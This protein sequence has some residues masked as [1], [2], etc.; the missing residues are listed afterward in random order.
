MDF[1][2]YPILSWGQKSARME[3]ALEGP[4]RR[5]TTAPPANPSNQPAA[6]S[7]KESIPEPRLLSCPCGSSFPESLCKQFGCIPKF[8]P[9]TVKRKSEME[10]TN[11]LL[12]EKVKLLQDTLEDFGRKGK[13]L[14]DE[15]SKQEE[16]MV[17]LNNQSFHQTVQ[18][19]KAEEEIQN[20]KK[21]TRS[22]DRSIES[23]S[24]TIVELQSKNTR[25]MDDREEN[26]AALKEMTSERDTLVD[27]LAEKYQ[28]CQSLSDQVTRI[29]FT[30]QV[31]ETALQNKEAELKGW[32]LGHEKE[33]KRADK[34]EQ[35]LQKAM[36]D[37]HDAR[38]K[39]QQADRKAVDLDDVFKEHNRVLG[40][41]HKAAMTKLEQAMAKLTQDFNKKHRVLQSTGR[42][43]DQTRQVLDHREQQL[44]NTRQELDETH[45]KLNE[46]QQELDAK[47]QAL[48]G[49]QQILEGTQQVLDNT[50]HELDETQQKLD[51]KQEALGKTQQTLQE[52]T[53]LLGEITQEL[54]GTKQ[55]LNEA[56]QKLD[57]TQRELDET[58]ELCDERTG[59]ANAADH[60]AFSDGWKNMERLMYYRKPGDEEAC[61]TKKFSNEWQVPWP[62]YF[63]HYYPIANPTISGQ[64]KEEIKGFL[65]DYS[66]NSAAEWT[67]NRASMNHFIETWEHENLALVFE[68]SLL[69]EYKDEFEM[70]RSAVLEYAHELW[71][72]RGFNRYCVTTK[73]LVCPP[74]EVEKANDG[75]EY[76]QVQEDE[77][78]CRY[79]EEGEDEEE[80]DEEDNEEDEE[81]DEEND[82]EEEEPLAGDW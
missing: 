73:C 51:A 46:K 71:T 12:Q 69:E 49:T 81:D 19:Q 13:I 62:I 1:G 80:D 53:Q 42:T 63:R 78:S 60:A 7:I 21:E 67:E 4:S 30:A 37:L 44:D 70:V 35:D 29:Q 36:N 39:L 77:V 33:K 45:Q 74:E 76:D 59:M 14:G 47:Q 41:R 50:Q 22:K 9:R 17:V 28:Q 25:L 79:P 66:R 5:R 2:I 68:E 56:Q 8:G 72:W 82:E 20:L 61:K 16:K 31:H 10:E 11:K 55:K 75:E 3:S 34:A 57:K 38:E 65:D 40:E 58:K 54:D 26:E 32:I 23:N 18:L 24:L 15:L 43:L 48:D 6:S 27:F 52:N 64:G